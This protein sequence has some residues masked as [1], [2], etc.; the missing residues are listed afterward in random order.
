MLIR[1][2]FTRKLDVSE[3]RRG[4]HLHAPSSRAA[5]LDYGG[6]NTCAL[7]DWLAGE[8]AGKISH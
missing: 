1:E 2:H 5:K 3:N 7:P 6:V 4:H 8:A